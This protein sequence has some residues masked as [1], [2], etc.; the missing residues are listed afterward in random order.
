MTT[1][2]G[3]IVL[4]LYGGAS[5]PVTC[6]NASLLNVRYQRDLLVINWYLSSFVNDQLLY[7]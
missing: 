3:G 6:S 1:C 5:P 7:S 4:V 2:K